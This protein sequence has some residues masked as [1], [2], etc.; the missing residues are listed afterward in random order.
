MQR[1]RIVHVMALC[2]TLVT[3]MSDWRWLD[4]DDEPEADL[5]ELNN[6]Q[7]FPTALLARAQLQQQIEAPPAPCIAPA[8]VLLAGLAPP[9]H[10]IIHGPSEQPPS[11]LPST[12]PV[13]GFM[14]LQC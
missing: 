10:P 6:S 11:E 13:Y 7:V 3:Q 1:K 2:L 9:D 4:L 14:S 8:P 5:F 12:D